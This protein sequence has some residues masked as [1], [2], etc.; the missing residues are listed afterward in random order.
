[1]LFTVQSA[2]RLMLWQEF[3]LALRDK[4]LLLLATLIWLLLSVSA[5]FSVFDYHQQHKHIEKANIDFRKQWNAQHHNP[6]E[7]AHFGTYIFKPLQLLSVFDAGLND[8]FGTTYRIE[9]HVQ[10]EVNYSHAESSD[11]LMRFGKFTLALILQM[12][13]PLLL[14]FITSRSITAEKESGTF[15]M[16]MAQG[17]KPA[18]LVWGKVWANFL[19]VVLLV[20]PLFLVL[21]L[22]IFLSDTPENFYGRFFLL[23]ASYLLY[24]LLITIIGVWVSASCRSS[25]SALLLILGLWLLGSLI[26]PKA[27]VSLTARHYPLMARATFNNNVREGYLKG[28]NGKDPYNLRAERYLKKL[29]QQYHADTTSQLPID[30]DGM[31]MQYNEDYQ[32]MVFSFY[33]AKLNSTF[34]QQQY[35]LS[36]AGFADPLISLKRLSMAM[37]GT[38]FYHHTDFSVQAQHYRN[39]LIRSLNLELAKH[40]VKNNQVY[41]ASPAFFSKIKDFNYKMAKLP[42]V[43]QLQWMAILSLVCWT[44]LSAMLLQNTV[45]RSIF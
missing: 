38:D 36:L 43:L 28:I 25:K 26:L 21:L 2:L 41:L 31:V 33:Q 39:E 5:L 19:L 4:T 20:L 34:S 12:F 32:N 30:A 13:V 35:L 3:R 11:A 18:I 7:A 9:A 6:H 23:S 17:L 29:L 40:P 10:H 45:K 37:A 22:L 42:Q 44:F 16:L 1:M 8:Y 27:I 24:Y 14:L 15:K